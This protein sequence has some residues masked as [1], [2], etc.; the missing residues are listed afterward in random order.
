MNQF[1]K[2]FIAIVLLCF[3]GSFMSSASQISAIQI[4]S[5]DNKLDVG[6]AKIL[7]SKC[8]VICSRLGDAV[9]GLASL[10]NRKNA[11]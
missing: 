2:A 7:A 6:N 4:L 1:P 10:L 5:P 3:G 9:E 8:K 11:T